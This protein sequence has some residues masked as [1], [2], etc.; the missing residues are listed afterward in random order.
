VTLAFIVYEAGYYDPYGGTSPGPRFLIPA[1]P[2]LAI[3][4]A[5]AYRRWPRIFALAALVSTA[6]MIDASATW[7]ERPGWTFVTVWSR[8][9]GLSHAA[10]AVLECVPAAGALA[11]ALAFGMESAR[12]RGE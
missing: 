10:G 1:L 9:G 5:P 7:N 11:L 6:L 4:L 12:R 3:G 2:F 8:W